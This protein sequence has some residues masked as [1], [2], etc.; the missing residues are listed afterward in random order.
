MIPDNEIRQ[1]TQHLKQRFALNPEIADEIAVSFILMCR[2]Y[3]DG[4]SLGKENQP[5]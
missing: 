5:S 1:I 2:K 3:N 4:I